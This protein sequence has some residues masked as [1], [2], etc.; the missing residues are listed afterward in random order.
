MNE[1]LSEKISID[2]YNEVQKELSEY[3]IKCSKEIVKA[4]EPRNQFQIT[5]NYFVDNLTDMVDLG[6]FK[7]GKD[8][9]Y[10]MNEKNL[11][12]M[13]LY[14]FSKKLM[15]LFLRV[16]NKQLEDTGQF[17]TQQHG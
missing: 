5:L 3:E 7:L 2:D 10:V 16:V 11:R 17:E 8:L 4:S 1:K 13:V 14:I 9:P 6:V 12:S 15:R